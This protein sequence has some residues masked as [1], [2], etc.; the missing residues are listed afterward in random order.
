MKSSRGGEKMKMTGENRRHRTQDSKNLRVQLQDRLKAQD[1]A[2]Q[3]LAHHREDGPAGRLHPPPLSE[4]HEVHLLRKLADAERPLGRPQDLFARGRVPRVHAAPQAR[5][6]LLHRPHG[7]PQHPLPPTA[8]V[9]VGVEE[10]DGARATAAAQPRSK[11]AQ[12]QRRDDEGGQEQ[13]QHVG[14]A[15]DNRGDSHGH[16]CVSS[17]VIDRLWA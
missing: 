4:E 1:E 13:Q 8:S 5:V 11:A 2:A 9:A 16:H 12:N 3:A 6:A 10:A 17:S 15:W 14:P 7:L